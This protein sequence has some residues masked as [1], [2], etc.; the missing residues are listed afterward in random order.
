MRFLGILLSSSG[1]KIKR[2]VPS[3]VGSQQNFFYNKNNVSPLAGQEDTA[4]ALAISKRIVS[5]SVYYDVTD[6]KGNNPYSVTSRPDHEFFSSDSNMYILNDEQEKVA[7][8]HRKFAFILSKFEII[9]GG[10]VKGNIKE[11]FSFFHP[12]W[13]LD[14][15]GIQLGGDATGLHYVFYR[16]G[17]VIGDLKREINPL[18]SVFSLSVVKLEDELPL[19][20]LT[21]AI[22]LARENGRIGWTLIPI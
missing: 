21:I 16:E 19:L 10:E 15:L 4:M 8:V 9:I 1:A 14:Y 17:K 5:T 12:K 20:A 22:D 18:T 13:Q 2:S 3:L 11:K 7:L 6:E